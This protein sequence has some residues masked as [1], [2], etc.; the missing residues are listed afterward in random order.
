MASRSA[1]NASMRGVC[2]PASAMGTPLPTSRSSTPCDVSP[3]RAD[4]MRAAVAGRV[5]RGHRRTGQDRQAAVEAVGDDVHP[6]REEV[7][8]RAAI[9][10][11]R[12]LVIAVDGADRYRARHAG[13][14]AHRIRRALLPL[15]A[16]T[17][18]P[19]SHSRSMTSAN[20]RLV[21]QP[22]C[23][24]QP[25]S[26]SPAKSRCADQ[27]HVDDAHVRPFARDPVERRD[28][29][30]E[31]AAVVSSSTRTA[32]NP[33]PGATPGAETRPRESAMPATFG[34]C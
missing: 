20:K 9:A 16:N 12:D 5:R 10:E 8:R 18:V 2:R 15:A 29:V 31:E 22:A 14:R 11:R 17:S 26:Q 3:G 13:R 19:R 32:T 23:P 28:P 7:E 34:P 30:G 6:R 21:V 4:N 1:A 24:L 25:R 33:A 27:A